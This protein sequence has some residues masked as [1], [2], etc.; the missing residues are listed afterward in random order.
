M[1]VSLSFVEQ[2]VYLNWQAPENTKV[3]R[4]R[5]RA[6]S[7]Q[8]NEEERDQGAE[9]SFTFFLLLHS[10][11]RCKIRQRQFKTLLQMLPLF[12]TT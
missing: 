8:R 11:R 3:G 9:N 5:L 6:K 12:P 1:F 10:C 2:P 7:L 4:R